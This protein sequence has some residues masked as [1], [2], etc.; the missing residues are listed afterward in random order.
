MTRSA[1][2]LSLPLDGCAA[3]TRS[4]FSD[5]HAQLCFGVAPGM[6]TTDRS[7]PILTSCGLPAAPANEPMSR[8]NVARASRRAAPRITIIAT[9]SSGFCGP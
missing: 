7:P 9:L 8:P 1:P 6:M 3:R 5:H 4:F 2:L